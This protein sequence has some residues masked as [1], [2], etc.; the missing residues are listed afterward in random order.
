[1]S[2]A[3]PG[4]LLGQPDGIA[5]KKTPPATK[6]PPEKPHVVGGIA[7]SST[8]AV[9]DV[10]R[11][12]VL[13]TFL[14]VAVVVL[15]GPLLAV[16]SVLLSVMLGILWFAAIGFL[17]WFP[18]RM[19]TAGREEALQGARH[20]GRQCREAL[21]GLGRAGLRVLRFFPWSLERVRT[22]TTHAL[23]LSGRAAWGTA[24]VGGEV[25]VVAGCGALVGAAYGALAGMV[26]PL[27]ALAGA[28]IAGAVGAAM[29]AHERWAPRH[30]ASVL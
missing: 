27:T 20:L 19:L 14:G 5:C 21:R 10:F 16:L 13:F 6:Y 28:V 29:T 7:V 15:A 22:G 12:L 9:W 11:K 30:R 1:M 3:G 17:V 23:R 24:R 8:F 18:F 4:R 25:A 26:V 2:V